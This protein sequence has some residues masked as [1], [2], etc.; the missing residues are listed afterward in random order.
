VF[1]DAR[2][3]DEFKAGTLSGARHL[4]KA[5]VSKAK[6]DGRLPMEDHNTRII[7]FGKDATQAREVAEEIARNAFHNISFYAGSLADLKLAQN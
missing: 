5:E 7:V 2:S 3:A 6:E 4:P 1:F